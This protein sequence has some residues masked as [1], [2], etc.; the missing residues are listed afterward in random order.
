MKLLGL[1][2][3]IGM[4]KSAAATLLQQR[5]CAVVDTDLLAREVVAPGQ[6]ALAEI[7]AAFGAEMIA[8]DGSLRRKEL[9]RH[10]FAD[11]ARRRQLEHILHPRIRQ[12]W[13]AQAQTWR[14]ENRPIGLV[15]IPLLFETSAEKELDAVICIACSPTIQMQ[16][17]RERGWSADEIARRKAAQW[18][19]EKK[20]LQANYV[21]WNNSGLDVFAEQLDRIMQC[22]MSS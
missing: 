6:S 5:G 17:L 19:I 21:V 14:A 9:A 1:T 3:G 22:Y 7:Q 12:R 4:G 20:M 8:P 13:L 10:V 18:P 16:R 15:V 11:D 2:G